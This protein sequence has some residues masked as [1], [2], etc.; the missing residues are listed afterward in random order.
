MDDTLKK[1]VAC[2][3]IGTMTLM[4]V[5]PAIE[6][7]RQQLCEV[8]ATELPHDHQQEPAPV[9]TVARVVVMASATSS[10]GEYTFLRRASS[11]PIFW[12][13]S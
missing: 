2:T 1:A 12:R 13:K 9:Q 11:S 3:V 7:E 6:C 8:K 5:E 10:L 4:S